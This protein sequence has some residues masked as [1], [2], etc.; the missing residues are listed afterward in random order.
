MRS[1]VKNRYVLDAF[2]VLAFFR[3]EPGG[4]AVRELFRRSAAGE[5]ELYLCVINMAEVLYRLEWERGETDVEIAQVALTQELP[6]HLVDAD[7]DLSVSAARLKAPHPISIADA[8]AAALALRLDAA[9]VTGDPDFRQV[10]NRVAI[11]WLPTGEA[12]TQ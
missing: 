10:E 3:E 2:A 7:L 8:Y 4:P 9:V 1:E 6:I 11:E 5:A 12:A